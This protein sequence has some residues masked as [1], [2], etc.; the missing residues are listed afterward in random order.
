MPW[1]IAGSLISGLFWSRWR[2]KHSRYYRRM[3]NPQFYVSVKRPI[4][5]RYHLQGC[6]DCAH[7]WAMGRLLW[8]SCRNLI[9]F[10]QYPLTWISDYIHYKVWGEITYSFPNFNGCTVEVWEWI[11]DFTP[12]FIKDVITYSC[13]EWSE[14]MSVKRNPCW[15]Y[16]CALMND[17][18]CQTI[19]LIIPIY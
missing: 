8:I 9:V 6:N 15:A 16:T 10:K 12:H 2:G 4:M 5:T 13:W 14:S 3:R 18:F 17:Y 1:C 7:L 19:V 11:S